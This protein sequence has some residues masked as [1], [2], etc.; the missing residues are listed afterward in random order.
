MNTV[1]VRTLAEMARLLRA[2]DVTLQHHNCPTETS[3]EEWLE[4]KFPKRFK[5]EPYI[6]LRVRRGALNSP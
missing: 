3:P 5:G 2:R 4:F 1:Q 6:P